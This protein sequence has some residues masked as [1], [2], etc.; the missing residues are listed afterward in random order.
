MSQCWLC[1]GVCVDV[2]NYAGV[3]MYVVESVYVLMD[4]CVLVCGDV[5]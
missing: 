3:M 2:Y 5:C 1:D 4:R